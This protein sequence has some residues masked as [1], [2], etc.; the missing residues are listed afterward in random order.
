MAEL[1]VAMIEGT[2]RL[3]LMAVSGAASFSAYTAVADN[4]PITGFTC[5]GV[6]DE[7]YTFYS[8]SCP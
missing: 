8:S 4:S 5:A 2:P 7:S 6:W 3:W 1:A